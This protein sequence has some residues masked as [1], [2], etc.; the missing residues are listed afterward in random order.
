MT[1]TRRQQTGRWGEDA[2]AR[3][4]ETKGARIVARNVRTPYGE[5]DLIASRGESLAF[6][7]VKTRTGM[8]FGFPEQ[9]VTAK[10]LEHMTAAALFFITEHTEWSDCAWQ[11][12]VIAIQSP[13]VGGKVEITHFE[14][15]TG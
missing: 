14:N 13:G 7:E 10:K 6:V 3:F 4:L 11:L 15:I 8:Q 2:A 1:K 9:G 5:I 12:D